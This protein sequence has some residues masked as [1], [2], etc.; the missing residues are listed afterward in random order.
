MPDIDRLVLYIF[1]DLATE[2][3]MATVPDKGKEI[4]KTPQTKRTLTFGT[5]A[6]R[7]CPRKTRR[8]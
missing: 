4:D 5:W 7:S 6:V 3:T 1:V 2:E 8:S